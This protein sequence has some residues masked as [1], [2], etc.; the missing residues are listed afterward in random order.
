MLNTKTF[1]VFKRPG[2]KLHCSFL[3]NNSITNKNVTYSVYYEVLLHEKIN[4]SCNKCHA[5]VP[6]FLETLITR[7]E[8]TY[9]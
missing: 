5:L 6:D 9:F 8:D 2:V 1:P 7:R 4:D 3:K